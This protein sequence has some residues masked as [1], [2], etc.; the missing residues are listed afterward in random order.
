MR[1]SLAPNQTRLSSLGH[2]LCHGECVNDHR[3]VQLGFRT[4]RR[5]CLSFFKRSKVAR[6]SPGALPLHGPH[7]SIAWKLSGPSL[8]IPSVLHLCCSAPP[9]ATF[10]PIS[11]MLSSR[12][13]PANLETNPERAREEPRGAPYATGPVDVYVGN[14]LSA[15]CQYTRGNASEERARRL[16]K[17][18][19]ALLPRGEALLEDLN[20]SRRGRANLIVN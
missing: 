17:T 2:V 15:T 14:A 7:A 5:Q 10:P 16:R 11:P 4:F 20:V 18:L 8:C 19:L 1:I 12:R 3:D 13:A 9:L 6:T